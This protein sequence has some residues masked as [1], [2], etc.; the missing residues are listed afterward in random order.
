MFG[1]CNRETGL[2]GL[3]TLVSQYRVT[4]LICGLDYCLL[5]IVLIIFNS[6]SKRAKA[7]I[8]LH[9]YKRFR[10]QR[11]RYLSDY[12]NFFVRKSYL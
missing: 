12:T 8:Y 5:S 10:K 3:F 7:R 4:N 9:R 1:Y 6:R 2:S 11:F